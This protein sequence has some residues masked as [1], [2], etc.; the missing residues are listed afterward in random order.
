MER[1]GGDGIKQQDTVP[2]R[3][4]H[5]PISPKPSFYRDR[6]W[7][8]ATIPANKRPG[9][10]GLVKTQNPSKESIKLYYNLLNVPNQSP[11]GL[12]RGKPL[13]VD[14]EC[15][16]PRTVHAEIWDG[17]PTIRKSANAKWEQQSSWLPSFLPVTMPTFPQ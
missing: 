16:V 5:D 12:N 6:T 15:R 1:V 11:E 17:I 13:A 2:E 9:V 14:A 7:T 10:S 3:S 4:M 8:A